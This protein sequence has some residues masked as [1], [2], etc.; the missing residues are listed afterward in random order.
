MVI[1]LVFPVHSFKLLISCTKQQHLHKENTYRKTRN[2]NKELDMTGSFFESSYLHKC[3]R[4]HNNESR[5][6][7]IS[8]IKDNGFQFLRRY[9]R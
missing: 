3:S 8:Y 4:Y 6:S 9:R 7:A 5:K 1:K 2:E